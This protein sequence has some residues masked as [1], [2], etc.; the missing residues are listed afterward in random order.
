MAINEVK[1]T[2]ESLPVVNSLSKLNKKKR[3]LGQLYTLPLLITLLIFILYPLIYALILSFYNDPGPSDL[4]N[5]WEYFKN[6]SNL[7][8]DN[9]F[10]LFLNEESVSTL[11][12]FRNEQLYNIIIFI[13]LFYIVQKLYK[14][15]NKKTKLTPLISMLITVISGLILVMII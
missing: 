9:L 2:S 4:R 5:G 15:L 14:T 8:L 3:L 12:I 6:L 7:S 11:G 1:P 10:N 13:L